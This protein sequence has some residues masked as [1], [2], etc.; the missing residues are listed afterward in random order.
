M[1]Y[2]TSRTNT[3]RGGTI[4]R[5]IDATTHDRLASIQNDNGECI[6]YLYTSDGRGW[7]NKVDPDKAQA[8]CLAH[9]ANRGYNEDAY[10]NQFVRLPGDPSP[11]KSM[12]D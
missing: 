1:K 7:G 2:A 8:I 5:F 4:L 10:P 3:D 9:L 6:V 12:C 11:F